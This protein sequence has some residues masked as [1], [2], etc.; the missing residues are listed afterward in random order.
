MSCR[1]ATGHRRA[2]GP[3]DS[4]MPEVLLIPGNMC[5]ERL[6][7]PV[8]ERLQTS[9]HDVQ[10]APRLDQ[11][12]IQAMAETLLSTFTK[13]A[14]VIGFSMGAIVAAE[15]ATQAPEYCA[16]LG[17]IAFNASADLPERA[18]VR[19]RQQEQVRQ[20]KLQEV[21]AN[22]LKPNYLAEARR[23]D[24]D[25]LRIVMQMALV[26]GPDVFAAQSE[27]LRLRKDLR[28]L[29]SALAMPVILACGSEDSLC[30]PD[31]HRR[32]AE[33]IGEN[34]TFSEIE[35]AGHLLP[36]EQPDALADALVGWLKEISHD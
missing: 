5:D 8:G 16:A 26:L 34:A 36:V 14:V 20:G 9:G 3:R 10:H 33:L 29:L 23:E 25:L 7:I 2:S 12:S 21:V 19:P 13:P 22:E 30:P 6:W 24:R 32:W 17:L 28:P 18:A 27:A 11:G 15:M 31:W 35:M 1:F 4:D